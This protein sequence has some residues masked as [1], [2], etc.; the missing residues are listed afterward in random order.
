[1]P[2]FATKS[3]AGVSATNIQITGERSGAA[4][5]SSR[6]SGRISI[7]RTKAGTQQSMKKPPR[8]QHRIGADLVDRNRLSLRHRDPLKVPG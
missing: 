5:S 4:P 8:H 1:M 2:K 6:N 3:P 7:T